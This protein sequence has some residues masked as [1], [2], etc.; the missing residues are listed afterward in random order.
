MAVRRGT[1]RRRHEVGFALAWAVALVSLVAGLFVVP[2]PTVAAAI[3]RTVAVVEFRSTLLF[4]KILVTTQGYTLYTYARD[5]KN[6]SKCTGQCLLNWPALTV[7][8]G[9]TPLGRGVAGLGFFVRRGGEHQVTYEGRPLYRFSDDR[10][11]GASNG[12][13]ISGFSVVAFSPVTS[14]TSTTTTSPTTT[15]TTTSTSST[16]TSTISTT[17]TSTSSTTTTTGG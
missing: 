17:S 15:T 2:S 4:G 8:A 14:T 3:K 10:V 1:T 5:T 16:T 9:V 11:A 13:G 12:V 7:A 6:D